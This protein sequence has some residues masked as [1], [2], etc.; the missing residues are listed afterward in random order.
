LIGILLH[1]RDWAALAVFV[2]TLFVV[3]TGRMPG[4]RL[5]RTGA[6][7][8]GAA[9]MVALGV[10]PLAAAYRAIDWNT[11][12]LLLGMMIVVAYLKAG[13]L[14]VRLTGWVGRR[15]HRPAALM[16]L[17]A[18]VSAVA[19][20]FLV[21]DTVC[22]ILAPLVLD[23]TLGMKRDPVP[24]L[25]AVATGANIGSVATITGNPQ[26]IMIGSF[27]GI[28]YGRFAEMLTP[29]A[30]IGLVLALGLIAAFYRRELFGARLDPVPQR[31][32]RPPHPR[33][34]LWVC[35]VLAAMILSF[36]LVAPVALPAIVA[37]AI[38][39][40]TPGIKP[41]RIYR[42]IDW[43]LLVLFCGLFVVV[44]GAEKVLLTPALL[45][46]VAGLPLG[47]VPVLALVSAVLSNLVSNV[48]AVLVLRPF[49]AHLPHQET[50][51]LTLAASSTLAGNLTILGSVANLIVVQ[52]AAARHVTIGFWTYFKLGAPL[53]VLSL[54]AAVA[55]LML[56]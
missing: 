44:A 6:A 30:V 13:G 38:L 43:P 34:A 29:I 1:C 52:K 20:A 53:T 36:F 49:V 33:L 39:L 23:L 48:P 22:L 54:V 5:D 55:V 28:G 26:N 45:R 25:L 37:A 4:S 19:S 2:G 16:A 32:R 15:V 10:L 14:F 51:W 41:A 9:L 47:Q 17:V 27:S 21:N 40:L 12:A 7:L 35:L 3:A 8:L 46:E 31:R 56:R 18:L 11:I 42:E 50:A 24:Y